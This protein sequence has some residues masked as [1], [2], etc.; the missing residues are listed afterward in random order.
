M[1][2]LHAALIA[3][4]SVFGLHEVRGEDPTSANQD[5]VRGVLTNHAPSTE[6]LITIVEHN[7]ELKAMLE[8]SIAIAARINPDRSTNPAQSLEEYYDFLDWAA[9]A[10]PFNILPSA[11]RLPKLYEQIDQSLNYFYFLIDQPLE[12]LEGRGL[13]HNTVQYVEP[14]R[15]WMILFTKRWGEFLSTPASWSDMFLA[16]VEDDERFGLQRGWYESP[17]NWKTFNQFFTRRLSS[18]DVRPIASPNDDRIVVAPADSAPQGIWQINGDSR[19]VGARS[20][21][22]GVVIKSTRFDSVANLLGPGCEYADRFA[23]G[24]LTHTFLDVNDYHRYHFPLSGKILEVRTIYADD[25]IGGVTTWDE[26]SGRYLLN[27]TI[28]GWQTIETR[29]CLIIDTGDTGVVAV[30]P[31]G[32]SQV[33]S[34]IF[35]ESVVPGA[36]VTKGNEMGFFLFGGSDIVMLFEERAGFELIAPTQPGTSNKYKHVLMGEA[37]GKITGSGK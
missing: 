30:M 24:V 11:E 33:S 35:N 28:P 20:A 32:M 3:L 23:N 29:A 21:N 27:D 18:P 12:E 19:I 4:L 14:F 22:S 10:M 37:Y 17:S 36:T 16:R 8:K 5:T 2:I 9:T 6:D 26:S 15:S 1:K 7:A 31:I 13:Y 25:A 34:V